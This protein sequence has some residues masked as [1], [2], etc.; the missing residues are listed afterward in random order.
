MSSSYALFR[1]SGKHGGNR[2]VSPGTRIP[3][4]VSAN[5]LARLGRP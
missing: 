4:S 3:I 2:C 5:P 1:S